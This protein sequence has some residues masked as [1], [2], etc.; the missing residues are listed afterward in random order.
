MNVFTKI[1]CWE[2]AIKK[3][4]RSPTSLIKM[5]I[6]TQ[7][8]ACRCTKVQH[9]NNFYKWTD[10]AYWFT[11]EDSLLMKTSFSF[12]SEYISALLHTGM[13]T[14][15]GIFLY[16]GGISEKQLCESMLKSVIISWITCTLPKHSE[17]EGGGGWMGRL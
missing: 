15:F 14:F 6:N 1:Y 9:L 2:L 11:Q 13:W 5:F 17:K 4:R 16:R 10:P 8:N 7:N 12:H 3:G